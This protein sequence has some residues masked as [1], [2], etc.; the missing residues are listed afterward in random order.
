MLS[1]HPI[2]VLDFLIAYRNIDTYAEARNRIALL[3]KKGNI[4]TMGT[5]VDEIERNKISYKK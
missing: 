5:L 4:I 1:Y 2:D 3:E